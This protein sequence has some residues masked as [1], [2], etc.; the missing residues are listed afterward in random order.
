MYC[1]LYLAKNQSQY[2]M[3]YHSACMFTQ[4]L[5]GDASHITIKGV[6]IFVITK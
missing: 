4:L 6:K 3:L 1:I 2:K 5:I